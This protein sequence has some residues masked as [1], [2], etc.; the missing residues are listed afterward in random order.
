[1]M[2]G[3]L[4]VEWDLSNSI[5]CQIVNCTRSLSRVIIMSQG[6]KAKPVEQVNFLELNPYRR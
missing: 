3:R 2:E 5:M 4:E 6:G 1:M